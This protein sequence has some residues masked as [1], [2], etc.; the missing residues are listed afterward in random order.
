MRYDDS[1]MTEQGKAKARVNRKRARRKALAN[2]RQVKEWIGR[3]LHTSG[4][5]GITEARRDL[6]RYARLV[7]DITWEIEE[8]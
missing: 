1:I 3:N 5:L 8:S 6:N 2:Y 4:H 7:C